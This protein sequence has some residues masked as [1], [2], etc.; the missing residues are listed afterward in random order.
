VLSACSTGR[1]RMQEGE[2]VA[3]FARAFQ[4]A[5]AKS[6]VVSLWEV[7]STA[8]VEFMKSF[9][10]HLKAGKGKAFALNLAR[11]EVRAKYPSPLY[12][13]PFVLYGEYN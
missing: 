6:I 10:G 9:Y 2:G 7:P 5:G 4:H 3:S 8:T 13:A 1:G 11:A 12:W